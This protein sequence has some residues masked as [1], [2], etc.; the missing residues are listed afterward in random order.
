MASHPKSRS[1][2]V[3]AAIILAAG[4]ARP[5]LAQTVTFQELYTRNGDNTGDLF[6]YSVSG[7]GN[8][9]IDGGYDD[10]I[11]GAPFDDNNGSE[12]GSAKVFVF[13]GSQQYIFNG[14][15]D[16]VSGAELFG[17]SVSEAGDVNGD[18]FDDLVVGAPYDD[19]SGT[20]TGSVSVF[21]GANGSVL[22][23]FYGDS[24]L[25]QFGISVSGA[26][27]V[28]GDGFGDLV[29]GARSMRGPCYDY[30]E[31]ARVFS[32]HDGSVLFT[33]SSN[34]EGNRFGFSVSG[35]GDVNGDG[36]A[37]II[38]GAYHEN[39]SV[40]QSGSTSVY[41]GIDGSL[42]YFIRGDSEFDFFGFSVSEAGDVN[43]DGFDDFMVGS[44]C[45]D[46]GGSFRCTGS[47]SVF[48]GA[49]GSIL[50]TFRGEN[51]GDEFGYAVSGAGDVNGDGYSDLI[52]GAH[53]N[54][55]NG[56]ESG[57][58]RVFSGADGSVLATFYGDNSGDRFG[59][60]VSGTGDVNADG[61]ADIIVGAPF[62]DN[63][64]TDS[65]SARVFAVL[66]RRCADQNEDR[67]VTSADFSAWVINFNAMD[68][69]A[70]VNQD[71][72]VTSADFSAWVIAFNQG[73]GGPTCVP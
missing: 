35:A 33:V 49:T 17:I 2:L 25:N 34:S 30:S 3:P 55:G 62:D 53:R 40:Q 43:G 52:V 61:L 51:V 10:F 38:V 67:Q 32:G 18:G 69:L 71:L 39:S 6:G 27:D 57:S 46:I 23:K 68:P 45:D 22:Y 13:L 9:L 47:A 20:Y 64:G 54:D 5:V 7:A 8:V 36:Y 1:C 65:G 11:V 16:A 41:S 50:Y 24:E 48:S 21:S 31:F 59:F 19:N 72:A 42:L 73:E 28:N 63:N 14:N 26:G 58:A 60:S 29:V 37:D 15:T 12:S 70:D 4:A 66:P 56:F 44:P